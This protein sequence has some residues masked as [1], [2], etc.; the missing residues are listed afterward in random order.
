MILII[1]LITLLAGRIA[2]EVVSQVYEL[3]CYDVSEKMLSLTKRT[4]DGLRD[5]SVEPLSPVQYHLVDEA[6]SLGGADV[7][8][9]FD[10]IYS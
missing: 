1:A 4:L 9:C 3:H 5:N 8:G 2:R 10:F 7:E 6:C